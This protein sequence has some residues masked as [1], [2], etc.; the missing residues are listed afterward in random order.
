MNILLTFQD[1]AIAITMTLT[2]ILALSSNHTDNT[3]YYKSK[4]YLMPALFLISIQFLLQRFGMLRMQEDYSVALLV[5]IA[6]FM[7]VAY[8]I[9]NAIHIL[10]TNRNMPVRIQATCPILYLIAIGAC[11]YYRCTHA[12]ALAVKI[13]SGA[14]F[15]INLVI[16]HIELVKAYYKLVH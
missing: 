13:V 14:C 5:N 1:F 16:M 7:P 9:T 10:L 11:I 3:P 4:W 8:M 6:I 2:F 15:L 12:D